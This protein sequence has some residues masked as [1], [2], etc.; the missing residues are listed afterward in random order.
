MKRFLPAVLLVI[1]GCGT[2]TTP[3]QRRVVT[4]KAESGEVQV[5]PGQE[6][7]SS[8]SST[9]Q[10][11]TKATSQTRKTA[12]SAG[13]TSIAAPQ[14]IGSSQPIRLGFITIDLAGAE[15]V[16]IGTGTQ[17]S[18][19]DGDLE[20]R[21]LVADLNKRGGIAGRKV[22]GFYAKVNPASADPAAA[23]VAGCTKLTED[24]KV[25]AVVTVLNVT[26]GFVD[27]VAKHQTLLINVSFNPGDDAILEQHREWLYSPPLMSLDRGTALLLN[28]LRGQGKLGAGAKLGVVVN[29]ADPQLPRVYAKTVKPML[30]AWKVPHIR[31]AIS[32][33]RSDPI[34]SAVLTFSTEQV[35]RVVFI[36]PNGLAQ[37]Q[38]MNFAEDQLYRPQYSFWDPDSPKF[39]SEN[40]PL[41]QRPNISGIGAL[42]VS[43]VPPSQHPQS[44]GESR[45]LQILR[46]AGESSTDR[47]SNLASTL[48]CD[49]TWAFQAVTEKTTGT[50]TAATW[51]AAYPT[52]GSSYPSI[53]TFATNFGSGR[54]DN[55]SLYRQLNWNQ[56]CPCL[57]FVSPV[58]PAS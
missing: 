57:T 21:A 2:L 17:V 47:N 34:A 18:F 1:V 5:G 52:V 56:A 58:R 51:R 29:E 38:F 26:Q 12:A 22:E 24:A 44:S 19:G 28:D 41:N 3:E 32:G 15:K 39:V 20:T 33:N 49:G 54:N 7:Q 46:E 31:A 36:S 53:T 27:C 13:G 6:T 14:S 42:P 11:S 40:A 25:F 9:T 10:G 30:D 37:L 8:G 48:Y 35:N 50:L 55:A 45:C 23:Y 4:E 16:L 43:D